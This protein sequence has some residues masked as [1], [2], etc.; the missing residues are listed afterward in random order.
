MD[1]YKLN[2]DNNH[3]LPKI[4][5]RKFSNVM[6]L[7]RRCFSTGYCLSYYDKNTLSTILDGLDSNSFK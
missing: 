4:T 6:P 7:E 3:C 1:I 5:T 2:F